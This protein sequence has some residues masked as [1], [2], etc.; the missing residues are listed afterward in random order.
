M[1]NL[2]TVFS[3]KLADAGISNNAVVYADSD[4]LPISGVTAGTLSFVSGN[5]S[6]YVWNGSSWFNVATI[7][8]VPI[9]ETTP[10]D[11]YNLANDGTATVITLAARDSEEV[12][13]LWSYELI[14]GSLGS[15]T[16]TND[17][18]VFT[19]TPSTDNSD[20]GEFTLAFKASDGINIA[21]DSAVFSLAFGPV[22]VQT[23]DNPNAYGTS[24]QDFFSRSVSISGNYAIAG[25]HQ[26]DAGARTSAGKAY[27]FN[28]STGALL[29]TLDNPTPYGTAQNDFFGFSVAISGNHAIVGAYQEDD[30]DGSSSGKAY[31]Y[32]VTT[33]ALVHTLDNPDAYGA[34]DNDQFGYSVG[35]SGNYAIVG[36]QAEEDAGGS[37]AG[38]AYIFNVTTG[39]LSRTLDN[40]NGYGTSASDFFGNAVAISGNYAIVGANSEDD[41]GGELSGKAY[42]FNVTTG[43]LLHTLDNPNAYGTSAFDSFGSSVALSDTYAIVGA[44][45]EGD[46]SGTASGK[47][48][49]FNISTGTLLHTLD[50]PNAFSTSTN[51]TF[52]WS[53]AI[54]D[55][56]AI[57]GANQED[58]SALGSTGKA[59][60]FDVATGSL[61][62]TL[63]NPNAYDTSAGD[64]F[65]YSMSTSDNYAIIGA[66]FEKDAGGTQSGKAYIYNLN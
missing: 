50:N 60:I 51:D 38:K 42:I 58:E 31:I 44:Y 26:E 21:S 24:A 32:N 46:A 4:D 36:A 37:A 19:I 59:Y 18:S 23:L 16:I 20:A 14:S 40:P 28:V 7:N 22:L 25:A 45:G 30:A 55:T 33:G 53:V 61:L 10:N 49:I 3:N 11:T 1:A 9:F 8:T 12:P 2:S 5:N 64:Q 56:Y 29:H 47:A 43:T 57:V 41:A 13:L 17:S 63:D 52:G 6:L 62:H 54:S 65:G 48:Y 66:I 34:G 15:T 39:A 27:I 35:I